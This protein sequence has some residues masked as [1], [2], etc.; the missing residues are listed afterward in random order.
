[1]V[2]S[3]IMFQPLPNGTNENYAAEFIELQNVMATNVPLYALDFPTNTWRLGNAVDFYFPTNVVL[4][5]DG[6]LLVVSFDP[7]TNLAPLVVFR[8][9]YGI[10]TNIPVYGPWS[11]RLDNAGESIELKFPDQPEVDGSVPY[12]MVEKVACRPTSPWPT[13]AAGTGQSL[14]RAVLLAY[15][16]DPVNWFAATATPGT[17]AAQT[18]A[19]VDADGVPDTWEMLHGSDPFVPDGDLDVDGDGFTVLAEWLAGTNPQDADSFLKFDGVV[20]GAGAVTLQFTAVSNRTY[21]ILSAPTPDAA[22]WFKV[23]DV[24]PASTNHIFSLDQ[25]AT[26]S[27]FYRIVTPARP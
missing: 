12:V 3:E 7:H 20:L 9:T 26:D 2:I 8:S 1:V 10:A 19:D 21:T 27:S 22:I 14:Q 6:R 5:P 11:G 17:L 24:P 4:P 16:N 13:D 23:A 18:S 15:A 25:P